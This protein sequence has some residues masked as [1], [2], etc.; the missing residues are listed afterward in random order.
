M[1]D[2]VKD[3][4][5]NNN[6]EIDKE[7]LDQLRQ[8]VEDDDVLF[9]EQINRSRF[10]SKFWLGVT[11]ALLVIISAVVYKVFVLD[12]IIPPEVLKKSI[13]VFDV[14]SLWVVKEEVHE[15]DF[16]GIVLVPRMSFRFRNAGDVPLHHI[17]TL[18]VFRFLNQSKALGEDY[19]VILKEPL[20]PGEESEPIVMTCNYGYRA[21]SKKAFAKNSKDW[22]NAQ[23]EIFVKSGSQEMTRLK[24]YY[25][26]RR[27]ENFKMDLD[28]RM[29]K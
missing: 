23:G 8:I 21:T 28:V 9:S 15:K 18:A 26:L 2:E 6:Q 10:G 17:Y 22:Q 7:G 19:E 5:Q 25:I 14:D 16:H 12:K 4:A 3:E 11:I 29:V 27:I 20:Q 1:P 24:T 13:E